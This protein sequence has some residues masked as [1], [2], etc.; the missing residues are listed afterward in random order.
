MAIKRYLS[1]GGVA[2]WVRVLAAN[3]NSPSLEATNER[4]EPAPMRCPLTLARA[5]HSTHAHSHTRYMLKKVLMIF[6]CKG[7]GKLVKEMTE[8][9]IGLDS[10]FENIY[11]GGAMENRQRSE[12]VGKRPNSQTV[13]DIWAL[14]QYPCQAASSPF[15]GITVS[16]GRSVVYETKQT[17]V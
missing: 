3:P 1:V 10:T 7:K 13:A 9:I 17:W 11:S 12:G 16:W 6:S 14:P 5:H 2:Q 4:R 15:K 8:G